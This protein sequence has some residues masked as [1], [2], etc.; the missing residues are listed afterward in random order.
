MKLTTQYLL[1]AA[2]LDQMADAV[3][4][5]KLKRQLRRQAAGYRKLAEARAKAA[6][7]QPGPPEA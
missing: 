2:K 4:D 5:P 1:D 3:S 7:D 6:A